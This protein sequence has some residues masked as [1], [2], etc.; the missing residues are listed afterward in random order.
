MTTHK[1][2]SHVGICSLKVTAWFALKVFAII[3]FF[4]V[5]SLVT[6]CRSYQEGAV[7]TTYL[8]QCT[9]PAGNWTGYTCSAEKSKNGAWYLRRPIEQPDICPNGP[10]GGCLSTVECPPH[11]TQVSEWDIFDDGS[12]RAEAVRHNCYERTVG[13]QFF[14]TNYGP[15]TETTCDARFIR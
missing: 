12:C 2:F 3:A 1:M 11:I 15:W 10:R 4:L 14:G 5:A 9:S 7:T 13:E 8:V 6:G